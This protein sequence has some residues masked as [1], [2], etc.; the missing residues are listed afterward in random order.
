MALKG[1]EK[2]DYL[3][4]LCDNEMDWLNVQ[5]VFGIK[6]IDYGFD[7]IKKIGLG[8][9]LPMSALLKKIR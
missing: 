4:F 6:K 1:F 2:Y 9:V 3:M 8:R 7:G 5:Q